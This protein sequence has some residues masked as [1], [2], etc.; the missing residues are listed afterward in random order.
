MSESSSASVEHQLHQ[1]LAVVIR[2]PFAKFRKD[3]FQSLV[4]HDAR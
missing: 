4:H 3:W 2:Q 1:P